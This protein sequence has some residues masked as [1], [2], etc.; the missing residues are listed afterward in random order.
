MKLNSTHSKKIIQAFMIIFIITG[1][2]NEFIKEN[3]FPPPPVKHEIR[4]DRFEFE[5]SPLRLNQT[6]CPDL[7]GMYSID[8]TTHDVII[9]RNNFFEEL[10]YPVHRAITF[11]MRV[12]KKNFEL[13]DPS[14]NQETPNPDAFWIEQG[15]DGNLLEMHYWNQPYPG[16]RMDGKIARARLYADGREFECKDGYIYFNKYLYTDLNGRLP[17][18]MVFPAKMTLSKSGNLL[19]FLYGSFR[20]LESKRFMAAATVYGIERMYE[21]PRITDNQ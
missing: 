16:I 9:R 20:R 1:C 10:K 4:T 19:Y 15:Q 3:F 12:L 13:L 7:R 14:Q 6:E 11:H 18:N 21:Y 2:S 17:D 8:A 5:Q